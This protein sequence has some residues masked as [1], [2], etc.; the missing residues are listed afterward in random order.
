MH[1][2]NGIFFVF[3]FVIAVLMSIVMFV[4]QHTPPTRVHSQIVGKQ[5]ESALN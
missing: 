5:V 4:N 1:N 2:S 3:F